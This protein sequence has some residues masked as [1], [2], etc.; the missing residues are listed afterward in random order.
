V[1]SLY[2]QECLALCRFMNGR[3][4]YPFMNQMPVLVAYFGTTALCVGAMFLISLAGRAY[5][6]AAAW[7]LCKPDVYAS[8]KEATSQTNGHPV[9][10][11]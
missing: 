4:P 6:R 11:E 10:T 8:E 7:A 5:T 9:K 2:G 1:A 3:Y